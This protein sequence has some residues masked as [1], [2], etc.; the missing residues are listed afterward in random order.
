[1]TETWIAVLTSAAIV[2]V[3]D[4]LTTCLRRRAR[5]VSPSAEP[6]L[7]EKGSEG[8]Q[9]GEVARDCH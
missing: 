6:L 2:L 9:D 3:A 7:T 5:R 4:L 8:V 1:M